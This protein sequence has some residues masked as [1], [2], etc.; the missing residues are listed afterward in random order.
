MK[1]FTNFINESI[2]FP[3][4]SVGKISTNDLKD[5]L[6]ITKKFLS[7]EGEEVV[8]YLILHPE[9][10]KLGNSKNPLGDFI[11]RTMP[12]GEE[13]S[14]WQNLRKLNKEGRLLECPCFLNKKQFDDILNKE[15][16]LDEIV[17]DLT[18]ESGRN[19][20]VRKYTPL[21]HKICRQFVGKSNL[22]YQELLGQAFLGLTYA[23]NNYG[24]YGEKSKTDKSNVKSYTFGQYAAER[25]RIE[26]LEGVKHLSR[27]VRVASSAQGKEKKTKGYITKNNSVSGDATIGHDDKGNNKTLF[28]TIKDVDDPD[29]N[30]NKHDE[31]TLWQKINNLL[32]K[33]FSQKELD[34][35]YHGEGIWGHEKMKKKELA[36]KYKVV[37][38]N[39]SYYISKIKKYMATNKKCR[40]LLADLNELYAEDRQEMMSQEQD[41]FVER[42]EH[43][44]E[45]GFEENLDFKIKTWFNRDK[46]EKIKFTKL[47][48]ECKKTGVVSDNLI[49][50]YLEDTNFLIEKFV[51]FVEDDIKKVIPE[52]YSNAPN[53]YKYSF[54]K[55]VEYLVYSNKN[56]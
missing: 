40:E 33:E 43:E 50:K 55:I 15:I 25:I 27:T 28:D 9:Y 38:S 6:S 37:E 7:P 46:S 30:L 10:I 44:V 12:A 47:L 3:E 16:S 54:K 42:A 8:K 21:V 56:F 2:Q 17:L 13:K 14:L 11:N 20:V 4:D 32:L 45:E 49:E 35:F 51:D 26:I 53:D 48:N 18:S 41:I 29:Y 22:D 19:K 5:Y 31:D 52:D 36:K 1:K 24:K 34:I 23:M 39:I